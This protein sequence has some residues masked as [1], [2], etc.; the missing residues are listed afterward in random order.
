[1]SNPQL[2]WWQKAVFYQI[3]PR[4]FADSNGDGMGD[5][6]GMISKLDY[7]K[8]LG[9]DAIWLSPHYPSPYIDCG[10]DISDYCGVAPEY[11]TLDQFQQ[12]LDRAHARGIKVVLDLVLNHTSDK[13]P[14]FIES[15]SSV[16]NLKRDWYI[17]KKGKGKNPPNNWFSAFG[18]SAWEYDAD[19]GEYYY[20]YFFKEQPDLNWH[21][22]QVRKAMFDAARFWLDLGV[23]GFRLDAV[24]TLF[25][26][27]G[28]PDNR[29][30]LSQEDLFKMASHVNVPEEDPVVMKYWMEMFQYQVDQPEVHTVMRELRAVVDAYEDR[31]L[32]GETDDIQFYGEKDDE[33][34]LVF[35][36][37]LMQ[38]QVL[39]AQHVRENQKK[40]LAALPGHAW[41]CNTMG[42]HDSPRVYSAFGDG[43]HNDRQAR[44]H[45]LMLLC[46]MGT[47]FL[48]N[49]E[50]IGMSDLL[51]DDPA[52]FRDPLS[53][54]YRDL[55]RR[56]LGCDDHQAVMIGAMRGRDRNR[57][58]MQWSGEV[59]GGFCPAGVEPWLPINPDF[60]SGVNVQHQL[61]DPGSLL[62]Y[63]RTLLHFR[64]AHP[65]LQTGDYEAI[66]AG[67]LDVLCFCR[68][69]NDE[70][71]YIIMNLSADQ[72]EIKL[73]KGEIRKVLFST[74]ENAVADAGRVR[75]IEPYEGI[76][77]S[78]S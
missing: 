46:L 69:T 77:G 5:L 15:R 54:L 74:S 24:G 34:H 55:A 65:A 43:I 47:P 60:S 20:H 1:M 76:I 73:S 36:F 66:D 19:T 33:L 70:E 41:P 7:L 68:K 6:G 50:E 62:G 35:N 2:K 9:I 14:W 4:S 27:D 61:D 71:I 13:H 78:S 40:R 32:I 3:Y 52:R 21:N 56:A 59:N 45:L 51:I 25:E 17:W 44:L 10:Y 23:D 75:T 22:P 48:Y 18:G 8:D 57:T 49:G 39:S 29:E 63:Y 28:Y 31:V 53:Q 64:K 67:R 37:P 42:N 26:K 38:T 58:P 11:G 16:S 30:G 72:Q 12:F